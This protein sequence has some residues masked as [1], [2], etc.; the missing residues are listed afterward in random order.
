MARRVSLLSAV[1]SLTFTGAY[2]SFQ[3]RGQTR[4]V[5]MDENAEPAK[6]V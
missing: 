5:M 4:R 3:L 6:H 2:T 1:I